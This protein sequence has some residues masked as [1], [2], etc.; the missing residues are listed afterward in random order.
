MFTEILDNLCR[1]PKVRGATIYNE[2]GQ[3]LEHRL[4]APYEES[5]ISTVMKDLAVSFESFRFLEP[6]AVSL[7][8]GRATDGIM[9]YMA[10][11]QYRVLAIADPSAN[12][13]F[14]HVAFSALKQKLADLE[15]Q[16]LSVPPA[17]D[18][19][20]PSGAQHYT[21]P[22]HNTVSFPPTGSFPQ[23]TGTYAQPTATFQQNTGSFQQHTSSYPPQHTSTFSA[24]ASS[25]VKRVVAAYTKFAGPAA[26][27]VVR[28]EIRM[29]GFTSEDLP[30]TEVSMLIDRLS[31][32]LG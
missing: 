32:R 6:A 13:A 1:V 28:E 15:G 14:I 20:P 23:P 16:P 12:L 24:M 22:L 17:T 5:F 21:G 31:A 25:T 9:A 26:R 29:L 18:S 27:I 4:Q 11:S 19:G 10:V 2:A 8:V 7:A 30:L 3:C